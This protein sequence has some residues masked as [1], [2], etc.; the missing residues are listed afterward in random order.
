MGVVN[1]RNI[2]K[3]GSSLQGV[4]YFFRR[5]FFREE[6]DK[7][8]NSISESRGLEGKGTEEQWNVITK[9]VD[10]DYKAGS[11]GVY[12]TYILTFQPAN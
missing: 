4:L 5:W 8:A 2:T 1:K 3:W 12:E 10:W 11:Y 9:G 7:N 6:F